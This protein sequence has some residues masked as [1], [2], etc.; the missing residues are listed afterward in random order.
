MQLDIKGAASIFGVSEKTILLWIKQRSLPACQVGGEHRFNRSELLE[1]ATERKISVSSE[2]LG[3]PAYA[4]NR[5]IRL[6]EALRIGGIFHHVGGTDSSSVLS[7]VVD[8]MPMPGDV[9]RSFL[10][11]MLIARES[12]GSTA[13]GD[14]I[15][16]PH[17][18]HPIV[19]HLRHPA[20]T[21]CFLDHPIDFGAPDGLPV[22]ILFMLA[23]PTVRAHQLLLSKL[24]SALKDPLFRAVLTRKGSSEEILDEA[25]RVEETLLSRPPGSHP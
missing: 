17:V 25:V 10:H 7:T 4:G 8:L 12:L 19:L 2:I 6:D 16:I 14:A 24:A 23:S 22:D 11:A 18:R 13:I 15:A 9:D 1:W 20:I 21:L 3:E 5:A